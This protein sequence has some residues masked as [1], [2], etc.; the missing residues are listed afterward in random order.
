MKTKS[1]LH[2]RT[3]A[4]ASPRVRM[5][6]DEMRNELDALFARFLP[7]EMASRF[8]GLLAMK[9]DRWLRIDPWKVWGVIDGRRV[10]EWTKT[11]ADLLVSP[12][13]ARHANE[14]VTVLRCGHDR[15]K[16]E[17]IRLREALQG[18]TAVFEGFISIVPGRL[19][20]AINHDGM[21]CALR[22][23]PGQPL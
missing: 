8:S 11:V 7:V 15:A 9:P 2:K 5:E 16:M 23:T 1:G 6:P 4:I 10:T 19:G 13:F 17:R 20:L 18:P 14:W 3:A 22:N 21:L 12:I